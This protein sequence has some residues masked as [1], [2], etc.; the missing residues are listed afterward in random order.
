LAD[1]YRQAAVL[2]T[3]RGWCQGMNR[4]HGHQLD[5]NGALGQ[6]QKDVGYKMTD[7]DP[8]L[9]VAEYLGTMCWRWNDTPGRT[10]ADVLDLLLTM[11]GLYR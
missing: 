5:L 6:A 11:E 3:R 2:L 9:P 8:V 7:P 10:L 4:N 1:V